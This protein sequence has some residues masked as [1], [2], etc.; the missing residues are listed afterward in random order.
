MQA[1]SDTT[2]MIFDCY[3]DELRVKRVGPRTWTNYRATRD[4]FLRWTTE[5]GLA[6]EEVTHRD[7]LAYI[8]SMADLEPS[9]V[10][11]HWRTLH[12]A[13]TRAAGK[14][15]LIDEDPTEGL[16]LPPV[17]HVRPFAFSAADLR[18][19]KAEITKPQD[20]LSFHLLAYTGMRAIEARRLKWDDVNLVKN[21]MRVT[22]KQTRRGDDERIVPIHPE[23][24]AVL[25]NTRS[26]LGQHVL[27][28]RFNS[29]LSG[30]MLSETAMIMTIRRNIPSHVQRPARD[31]CHPIRRAVA[32]SLRR[33]GVDLDTIDRLMGWAPASMRAR[34]YMDF[35]PADFSRAILKL[36]ADDPL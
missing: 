1:F 10:Q 3:E 34:R 13:Y 14:Y 32:S 16:P 17:R 31:V 8:G 7:M 23:L 33:N 29:S 20:W 30:E 6:P 21:T 2:S 9:T 27:R 11:R 22:G 5:R 12:A 15:K 18:A 35:E 25:L 36:W 19:I 4:R 26:V 24:R 28:G